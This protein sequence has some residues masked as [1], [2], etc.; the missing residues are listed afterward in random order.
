MPRLLGVEIPAEK[1]IEASLTYI[2]GIGLQAES[3]ADQRDHSRD[4]EQQNQNR[5]RFAPRH[6]GKL[7][8]VAGDQ[9]LSRATPPSRIAGARSANIY[10]RAHAQGAAQNGRCDS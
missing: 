9:L 1:R 4:H 8:A 5:G 3:A 7:E 10:Q 6:S 2:Y